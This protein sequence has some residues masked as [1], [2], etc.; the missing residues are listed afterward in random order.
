MS[1][2]TIQVQPSRHYTISLQDRSY[3]LQYSN[4]R[5]PQGPAGTVP[6]DVVR[7]WTDSDNNGTD[8]VV[9][10]LTLK[11]W[12]DDPE[13]YRDLNAA[14]GK[15]YFDNEQ[16]ALMDN[17][18]QDLRAGGLTIYDNVGDGDYYLTADNTGLI[19]NAR[20]VVTN[21]NVTNLVGNQRFE[22]KD[23]TNGMLQ[24][25]VTSQQTEDGFPVIDLVFN[26]EEGF[27]VNQ[28]QTQLTASINFAILRHATYYVQVSPSGYD[29]GQP[30]AF[31]KA[32]NAPSKFQVFALGGI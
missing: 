10:M 24:W 30:A 1:S 28:G 11:L 29:V 9:G 26:A 5:G 23:P 31:R 25:Y 27:N 8:V 13:V 22:V 16:V 7:E 17:G 32:I 21:L 18:S 6:D 3:V 20:K 4:Q 14:N 19:F 15:L 12:D 2:Y